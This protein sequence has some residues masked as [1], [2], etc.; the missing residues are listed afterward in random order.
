[1]TTPP[2]P[3]IGPGRLSALGQGTWRMG[4][5]PDRRSSEQDALRYGI[6]EG[7][8]VIDTAEMYGDGAT[9]ALLGDTL[10]GL[11]D[12]VYLV[13]K[14]YPHNAGGVALQ[15]ACEASLKRLRTD[16]L[17]LYL[18]HWRGRV[19]LDE[20]VAGMRALQR[21]GKIRAWGVSNFDRDDMRDLDTA[22]G[23]TRDCA[24]NQVL[25]NLTRRGPEFDLM[26]WMRARNMPLM[27]YSPLEQGRLSHKILERIAHS[28]GVRPMQIALAWVLQQAGV[29]AIPKAGTRAHVRMNVEAAN[30]EL[31]PLE[32]SALDRAFPPPVAKAPLDML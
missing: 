22:Q 1:M 16:R 17:D 20:T 8:T 7:L 10:T 25:Y 9:E 30:L 14:V 2:L 13:S 27:A 6:A 21:A 28:R 31:S 5:T 15:R 11:R 18:L 26:P 29:I 24:C 32:C 23:A 4:E 19:P 3:L 12:D